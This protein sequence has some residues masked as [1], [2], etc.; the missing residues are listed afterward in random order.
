MKYGKQSYTFNVQSPDDFYRQ[1]RE[2]AD[3]VE[4]MEDLLELGDCAEA[5]EMLNSIGIKTK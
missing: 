1:L 3:K 2:F 5:R 4:Q